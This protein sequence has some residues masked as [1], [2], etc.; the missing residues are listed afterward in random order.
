MWVDGKK[1][2]QKWQQAGHSVKPMPCRQNEE[3]VGKHNVLREN[4][5]VR[6]VALL[7]ILSYHLLVDRF[8]FLKGHLI[9]PENKHLF[10]AGLSLWTLATCA[11][12]PIRPCCYV[13]LRCVQLHHCRP[14]CIARVSCAMMWRYIKSSNRIELIRLGVFCFCSLIPQRVK[15]SWIS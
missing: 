7:V 1:Q 12:I 8:R 4:P 14:F 11:P 2:K 10:N 5:Q 3:E 9:M 15:Q 13:A 6:F